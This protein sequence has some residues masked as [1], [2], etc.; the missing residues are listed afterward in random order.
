MR[1]RRRRKLM[2]TKQVQMTGVTGA[3]LHNH[4]HVCLDPKLCHLTVQRSQHSQQSFVVSQHKE[5]SC[6][7]PFIEIYLKY[8]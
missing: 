6:L 7:A 5:A 2:V 8:L 4:C 1:D 3:V